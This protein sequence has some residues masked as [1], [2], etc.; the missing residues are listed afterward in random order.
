M[1]PKPSYPKQQLLPDFLALGNS[2]H[3]RSPVE[4]LL[5]VLH[6]LSSTSL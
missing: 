6:A 1:I 4:E 5:C 3:S 2:F